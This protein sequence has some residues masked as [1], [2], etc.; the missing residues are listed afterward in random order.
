M[1]VWHGGLMRGERMMRTLG[2]A[3]LVVVLGMLA[4]GALAVPAYRGVI[5]LRQPDGRSFRARLWGDERRHGHETEDGYTVEQDRSTRFWHFVGS[6]ESGA[7]RRLS[8]RPG[9]DLPPAG[10]RRGVRPRETTAALPLRSAPQA[11]G[12]MAI[13]AVS[14]PVQRVVPPT[15]TGN[16]PVFLVDFSDT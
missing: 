14:S 9:I 6:D 8:A 10:L 2:R 7:V 13:R 3:A 4:D 12:G 1:R 15:G 11:V 5:D 16:V